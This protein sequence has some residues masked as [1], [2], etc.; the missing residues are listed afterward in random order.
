MWWDI[1]PF[2]GAPKDPARADLDTTALSVMKTT[3]ALPSIPCRESA[4]HGLGHW[5]L[6]YPNQVEEIIDDARRNARAWSPELT[7]YAEQARTGYVL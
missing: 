1:I 2:F 4:L 7:A 6:Y 5:H 3:L